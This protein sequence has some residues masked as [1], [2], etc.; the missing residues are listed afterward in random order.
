MNDNLNSP[1]IQYEL[2]SAFLDGD[3]T[4]DERARVEAAPELMALVASMRNVAT[5]IATAPAPTAAVRES[6]L[7][8]AMSEFDGAQHNDTLTNGRGNVVALAA[9]RWPK[10]VLATA[11]AVVV[12]GIVGISVSRSGDD[13]NGTAAD[14]TQT[15]L[16]EDQTD[17]AQVDAAPTA[18]GSEIFESAAP[19]SEIDTPEQL[20]AMQLPSTTTVASSPVAD[21]TASAG[22]VGDGSGDDQRLYSF[23]VD[24]VACMTDSQ[25][26]LADIYYQGTLAIAVRDTVTGVTE[27]IDATC[28]VLA[29]VTP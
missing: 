14:A 13:S 28:T 7:A 1:D 5:L 18:I 26:F 6:A 21:T 2:A 12:L 20:S 15:K 22:G 29:R 23:N 9:R 17:D 4:A 3:V 24:A 10:T 25:V 8:A 16:A 11:A 19:I 27:A